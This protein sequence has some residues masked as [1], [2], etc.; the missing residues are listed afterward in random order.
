MCVCVCVCVCAFVCACYCLR[1]TG[2]IYRYD[3]KRKENTGLVP[4]W[5]SA[6]A[7]SAAIII[8]TEAQQ[9]YILALMCMICVHS[10]AKL[11]LLITLLRYAILCSREYRATRLCARVLC[12]KC[13]SAWIYARA[14]VF[15]DHISLVVRLAESGHFW[16]LKTKFPWLNKST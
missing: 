4:V 11:G 5:F 13:H 2:K 8:Y 6:S 14:H 12:S 9:V 3:L 16:V 1:F 7:C 15:L 10:L